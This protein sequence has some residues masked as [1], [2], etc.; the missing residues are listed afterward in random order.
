MSFFHMKLLPECYCRWDIMQVQPPRAGVTAADS[1]KT[2]WSL[3][4]QGWVT[5]VSLEAASHFPTV[6]PISRIMASF[7]NKPAS[8]T[9]VSPPSVGEGSE[10]WGMPQTTPAPQFR[11]IHCS[12]GPTASNS[13]PDGSYPLPR[14]RRSWVDTTR[15]GGG[16]QH[17]L[18]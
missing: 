2:E 17:S 7:G 5:S 13:C 14:A 4:G 6:F 18:P 3:T 16:Q 15:E 1:C 12:L 9:S 8:L 11:C 10:L